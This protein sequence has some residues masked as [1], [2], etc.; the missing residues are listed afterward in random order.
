MYE[1]DDTIVAVSSPGSEQRT[2]V[3]ISGPGAFETTRKVFSPAV[4]EEARL[5]PGKI[6]VTNQLKLD[7]TL[8]FFSSPNSYTGDD[9][10]E[11]HFWANSSVTSAV[12]SG[13]L[14]LGLRTAEPGE[15]TAR[16]YLNNKIDLAQAEAVNEIVTG[17]NRFQLAAAE[18]LL[19]G[20]LAECTQRISELLLDTLTKIEAGLDFSGE[21]IEFISRAEALSRLAGL[22]EELQKLLDS[23]IR[24]EGLLDLPAVG[25]A[26]A[27]NAGKSTLGNKLLGRD[28]SIVS[29]EPKTTRDVL[30]GELVLSRC[31]CVLFDCAGLVTHSETIIDRLARQAAAEALRNAAVVLFCIDIS[32]ADRAEDL[33]IFELIKPQNLIP[34]ATKTDLLSPEELDRRLAVLNELFGTD[35]LGVSA[36]F[37]TRLQ[38]LKDAIDRKIIAAATP[39]AD[40]HRNTQYAMRDTRYDIALTARHRK[41]VTDAV[42]NITYAADELKAGNDEVAAMLLR[43]AYSQIAGIE[44]HNIDEKILETIFSHFCIGK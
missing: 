16:A 12:L 43:A 38:H 26:G 15:F 1:L 13:L 5:I 7:A 44:Q 27:P 22:K 8:Y 35:F 6:A 23:S 4:L 14:K 9:L 3:R 24:F 19:S 40:E 17:S 30:T 25:V 18:K 37:G 21:D 34:V 28:R 2:I 11:I 10:A 33:A 31:R 20:R 42:E 32:K 39:A 41:A 36:Q 29:A